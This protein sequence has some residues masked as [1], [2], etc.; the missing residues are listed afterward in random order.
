MF[1]LLSFYLVSCV[2]VGG[3]GDGFGGNVCGGFCRSV[4]GGEGCCS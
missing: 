1:G 4:G 3:F 2:E